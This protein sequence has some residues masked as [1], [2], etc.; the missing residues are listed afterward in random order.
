MSSSPDRLVNNLPS[1]TFKYTSTEIKNN[2]ILN[3]IKQQ[4]VY[5]Y[6]YMNSFEKFEETELPS[7]DKFYCILNVS[8]E[9]YKQVKNVWKTCKIENL[10]EY[11]DLYLLTDVLLLT[12]VF[13]NFRKTCLSYYGLDPCHYLTLGRNV[14]DNNYQTR[15][16]N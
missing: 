3:L 9:Q 2:K 13:E 10:H 16:A 8:E 15:T 1:N 11:H 12:D 5:P 14:K 6:D 7:K 4:G